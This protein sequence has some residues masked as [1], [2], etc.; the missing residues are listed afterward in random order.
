MRENKLLLVGLA[1]LCL[2]LLIWGHPDTVTVV[3]NIPE[4]SRGGVYYSYFDDL[5]IDVN[6][7]TI[8][9][10]NFTG[11][12]SM[13]LNAMAVI[14][15]KHARSPPDCLTLRQELDDYTNTGS[16]HLRNLFESVDEMTSFNVTTW[17][18][19]P[20]SN[21]DVYVG[22]H[23]TTLTIDLGGNDGNATIITNIDWNSLESRSNGLGQYSWINY[24]NS[25]ISMNRTDSSISMPPISFDAWHSLCI[26]YDWERVSVYVDGV[27]Y[28]YCDIHISGMHRLNHVELSL[29][30]H[31]YA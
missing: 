25:S 23:A 14:T 17:F 20:S 28:E 18:M 10:I 26:I 8:R 13:T 15:N 27:L 7:V 12:D 21:L 2:F 5:V 3:P 1:A 9:A 22:G 31:A 6:G 16:A 11:T 19:V 24:A 30:P 4:P 29:S